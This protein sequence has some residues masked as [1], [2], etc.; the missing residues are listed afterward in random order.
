MRVWRHAWWLYLAL[1]APLTAAYLAGILND[2]PTYNAIGFSGVVAMF[3]GIRV[4][5]PSARWAWYVLAI[6]QIL[7]VGGDVLAYNYQALFGEALPNTSVADVLYLSCYP[8]TGAGLLLLI[9]RRN[10][11]RD[12]ASL[13]DS[14]VVTVGL[15]L[16]SWFY[17][18][19]PLARNAA[20]PLGTKLVAIAYPL[21]DLLIL[22]IAMR[23]AV[24]AGRRS[25]AYFM[26]ICALVLVLVSDSAYG[27][28]L[29]YDVHGVGTVLNA[30]WIAAHL[31]FGAAALH[32]SMTTV[33]DAGERKL[34]LSS[35]RILMIAV[36]ALI[37]PVIIVSKAATGGSG[38]GIIVAGAAAVVL[39]GLVI[40]RMIGLARAQG[41]TLERER[42]MRRASDAFVTATS[43]PE[44]VRAAADGA[45]L[46]AGSAAQS[47]VLQV[48]KRG[49]EEWLTGADPR[50]TGELQLALALLPRDVLDRLKRR[51]AIQISDAAAT[52]GQGLGVRPTLLVPILAQGLFVGAVALLDASDISTPTRISLELLATQVGLALESAALT[53]S[54]L[55][56]NLRSVFLAN[57]SHEL[58]TP[59][60]GVIGM[61]DLLL[62]TSLTSD[63]REAGEQAARSGE[64]MLAIIN[65]VLD[66]AKLES[67]SVELNIGA[68]DLRETI[69]RTCAGARFEAQAKGLVLKVEIE[70]G[71][72]TTVEGDARRVGQVLLNLVANAV[73]FTHRGT[74]VVRVS[75]APAPARAMT[76]RCEVT[77]TGIGVDAQTMGHIFEPFTQADA[78][79]TRRYGGTGLGLA[80]AKELADLMGGRIGG[81]SEL[82]RGSTFWFEL[83][84]RAASDAV[85]APAVRKHR[86]PARRLDANAPTVMVVEDSPVNQLVARRLV[87]SCGFHA[88]VVA[89]GRQALDALATRHYDAVLMD[90][91]M[92]ELDGYETTRELRRREGT[93]RHTPVIALTAHTMAG[94]RERCIKAGMDDY[95]SKP[96]GAE[97]IADTL[98]RW[99]NK[100]PPSPGEDPSRPDDAQSRPAPA[101][102]AP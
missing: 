47:T 28:S 23:L 36:A 67:G 22:G 32:P 44:I 50:G 42:T 37:A 26:V 60:N 61:I 18:I 11:G 73:K 78:S 38:S 20:L 84:L 54:A 41:A 69:E 100:P 52:L 8:V 76:I 101:A 46:L 17:L 15:A 34:R 4:N 31:L 49:G 30:G 14:A 98:D 29:L 96:V 99:I 5:R 13:I 27:W 16:L 43:T 75:S 57:V 68:F 81:E 63:Q 66:I 39:F 93:T 82:G 95:L 79:T 91:Q 45:G 92:P 83:P 9:R 102:V 64:H 21:S 86:M 80:I 35:G 19:E 58:R 10:P 56:A 72:E 87:E 94:D 97:V 59:M 3:V 2:G 33:A 25:L 74:V 51:Q 24:G 85:L 12:W 89:D 71:V 88:H 1:I 90:C 7:F 65:D 48:E 53:E 77:D 6:G 40:A 62:D 70:A 55:E